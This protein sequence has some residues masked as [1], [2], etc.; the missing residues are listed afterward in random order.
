MFF[1]KFYTAKLKKP[2]VSFAC[3]SVEGGRV[4]LGSGKKKSSHKHDS[5]QEKGETRPATGS[6]GSAWDKATS[7][8]AFPVPGTKF[9]RE[10]GWR[11]RTRNKARQR[12]TR[13][14]GVPFAPSD[15]TPDL[16]ALCFFPTAFVSP[17]PS[18]LLPLRVRVS[19]VSS[20]RRGHAPRCL[21]ARAGV[22]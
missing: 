5:V 20:R 13:F 14:V 17:N 16:Q 3:I 18:C 12:R 6:C 11:E 8:A 7:L 9:S 19:P 21:C 22:A 1:L 4:T 10:M 2:S 15:K